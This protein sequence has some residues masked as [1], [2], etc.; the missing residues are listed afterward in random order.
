MAINTNDLK[1]QLSR[2]PT[3]QRAELAR[4][5][6]DSLDSETEPDTDPPWAEELERRAQDFET[7]REPGIPADEVFAKLRARFS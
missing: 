6:I 5:L 2:L 7:G 1:E 3:A 4:Y